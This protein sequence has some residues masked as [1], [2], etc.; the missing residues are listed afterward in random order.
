MG[1]G[2][3]GP[4]FDPVGPRDY[5][6]LQTVQTESW[7]H[8]ASYSVDTRIFF[9]RVKRPGR[10]NHTHPSRAEFKNEWT[11]TSTPLYAFMAWTGGKKFYLLLSRLHLG[12][13]SGLFLW[14]SPPKSCM[15]VS[16]S[17]YVLRASST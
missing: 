15:D 4:G 5:S 6:F 10:E 9:L 11:C 13:E 16:S 8:P 2:M 12:F 3:D 17:Q 1:Y 14:V 7:A